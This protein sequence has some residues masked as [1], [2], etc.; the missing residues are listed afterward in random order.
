MLLKHPRLPLLQHLRSVETVVETLAERRHPDHV[1][2]ISEVAKIANV[3]AM[4]TGTTV[5]SPLR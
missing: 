3:I 1:A 2:V 4:A 5:P